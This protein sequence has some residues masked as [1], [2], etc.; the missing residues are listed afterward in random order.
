M[1][2]INGRVFTQGSAFWG[3]ED[4]IFTSSP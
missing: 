4:N 1:R 2:Y 3:L